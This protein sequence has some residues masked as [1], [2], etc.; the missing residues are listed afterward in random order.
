MPLPM[1]LPE[2]VTMAT[3]LLRLYSCSMIVHPLTLA[4]PAYPTP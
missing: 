2:P 3:L 1:P 4:I